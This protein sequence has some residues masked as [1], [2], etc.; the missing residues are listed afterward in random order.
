VKL[1][2]DG[3]VNVYTLAADI[4]Q[5]SDT[6]ISQI[7]AEELGLKLE[8]VRMVTSDTEVTPVDMGSWASRVTTEAGNAAKMAAADAK[9]QLFEAIGSKLELKIHQQLESNGCRI[10]V[11]EAPKQAISFADAVASAQSAREGMPIIGR[12]IF[13]LRGWG[14]IGPTFSFGAQVAE[15]EVDKETGQVKVLNITTAHD[16]GRAIN[17]MS[18]EGQLEGSIHM[19]LGYVLTE[20]VRIENGIVLN[21]SL[22]D[23]K[24]LSALDMPQTQSIIVETNDPIGPYGAKEAGEG[25]TLPTAPAVIN[26]IYD[27]VGIRIHDLPATPEKIIKALNEKKKRYPENEKID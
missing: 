2:G 18:V 12:G 16:C 6:V 4:G 7:V 19:A 8:D 26:A 23:Y 15:V 22:V 17:P 10:Y 21:P 13:S 27:A 11:K 3:T 1:N 25:L 9:K 5:G 24:I 20:E 14:Q